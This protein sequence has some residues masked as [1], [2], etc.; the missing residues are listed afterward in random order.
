MITAEHIIAAYARN[1]FLL[2][3]QVDG[4]THAESLVQPPLQG[5]CM[6]WVIG[7][8]LAYRNRVLRI[9]GLPPVF[10]EV[11][12]ARYARDSK[13]IK[14]DEAGIGIFEDMLED[15]LASQEIVAAGIRA[16]APEVAQITHTYGQNTM[17]A[18]EWMLFLMRH[19]SYHV[20]NLEMLREVVLARR[21]SK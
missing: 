9:L 1:L 11:T 5:N 10:D 3:P 13:P 21:K 19:E 17:S 4:V 6:N 14:G 7:H 12:A 2:K 18:A 8:I 15:L 16:L 20:G